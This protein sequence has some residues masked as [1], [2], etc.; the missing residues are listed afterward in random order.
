MPTTTSSDLLYDPY[1]PE[2]ILNPHALFRRMRDEAPLYYSEPHDFYAI[3][4]F[5]DIERTLV[6]RETFISRKGVTLD[7]LKSDMAIPPGT[8]IFEDPPT[9]AIHRAL[10]SRMFTPRRVAALEHDIRRLCVKLLDPFVGAGQFD[11]V[12]DLG[13]QVPMRVISMLLGIPES[14]QEAIRDHFR[15]HRSSED[16]QDQNPLTGGIFADYV[17]WRVEHPADDIMTQLL[18]SEFED[19]SGAMRRLTRDELLAYINI[20]A[21]AGNETTR[22]LIGWTG[23]LL[24]EHP[25][26]RRLLVEDP[27]LVSN[28]IEEILRFEPNTLQNCRYVSS[29]V[30][31]YGHVVPAG[32]I[33]VTLTP[34]GNRDERHFADPDTFD[35]RRK[36]DRHLSFGF[37]TH[38]CLGQALARLEGR[39][40]LEEVLGRFPE[41]DLELDGARFMYHTDMRGY[42]SLPVTLP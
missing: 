40:V 16:R 21:A 15:G 26:Q 3:S 8:V 29:D 42:E 17:D 22:V 2:T 7:I 30:E 32:S 24:A 41:W 37:G 5:D 12:A 13:S 6:N 35:V 39:I 33:M 19:E 28:A 25:D 14:D 34:S 10:L 23:K 31:F 20:V 38:Y 18:Y 1:D 36:I 27:S 11:F 9:H 4:R